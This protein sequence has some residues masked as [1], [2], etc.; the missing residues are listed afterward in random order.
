VARAA[1][2]WCAWENSIVSVDPNAKPDA[3]RQEPAF[4]LA[5]ARIVTHYFQHNAWLA[6]GILLRQAGA[7]DR[8]AM[9]RVGQ[10]S[11]DGQENR[12][13]AEGCCHIGVIS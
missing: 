7:Q 5:F 11:I 9:F 1:R 8:G 13:K 12:C 3:R 4:Q 2:N 10:P 6:D